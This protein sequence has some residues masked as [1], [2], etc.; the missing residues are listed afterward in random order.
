MLIPSLRKT[1]SVFLK[2]DDI[3]DDGLPTRKLAQILT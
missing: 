1:P 3:R 2:V